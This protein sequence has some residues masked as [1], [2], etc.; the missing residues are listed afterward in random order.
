[1]NKG[2]T[3]SEL[4]AT[5]A[6]TILVT[7]RCQRWLARSRARNVAIPSLARSTFTDRFACRLSCLFARLFA[8][9]IPLQ[10]V[11]LCPNSP[12]EKRLIPV[13]KLLQNNI[14]LNIARLAPNRVQNPLHLHLHVKASRWE[15][16]ADPETVALTDFEGCSFVEEWVMEDVH[17]TLRD[18]EW[19]FELSE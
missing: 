7:Q 14:P 8:C 2:S 16:A 6:H 19:R 10:L 13:M 3:L 11:C 5:H 9:L 1:M 17:A 18:L 12:V 4:R 15:K